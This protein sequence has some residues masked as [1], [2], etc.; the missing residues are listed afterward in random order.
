MMKI[1]VV[2]ACYN[3]EKVIEEQLESLLNQTRE[4]D[5]V[6]IRDDCSAD[7]TAAVVREFIDFN[8]LGD[9]WN[10]KRNR[11]NCGYSKNFIGAAYE[12][13]GDMIFFCDQDDIWKPE[14]IAVMAA[15]ME[16]NDGIE[17]LVSDY[18]NFDRG[19]KNTSGNPK[20]VG[21]SQKALYLRAPGCTMCVS[22]T[23]LNEVRSYW[24]DGWAHDEFV[25]KMALCRRS[26]YH[27]A[28]SGIFRRFHEGNTSGQKMHD[29]K[30]RHEY[31]TR[32]K[33]SYQVMYRYMKEGACREKELKLIE[34]NI[35]AV[36]LRL[37]VIRSA[38][39]KAAVILIFTMKRT[40]QKTRAA[41]REYMIG[42]SQSQMKG[43][44]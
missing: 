44:E 40:Y 9:K 43:D 38:D 8:T 16:N 26:L 28:Y 32:L 37:K 6:I 15:A 35:R 34:K 20:P 11:L 17:V 41:A 21:W 4:I 7:R 33:K 13:T 42:V 14:K 23:M 18:E 36:R 25:W 29:F 39:L 27:M 3:G 5:E 10:F 2:L 30:V 12:S 24:F 22:R 19:N 31:L 1:S